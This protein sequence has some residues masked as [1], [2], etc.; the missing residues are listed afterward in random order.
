M[1]GS[2][3]GGS[4]R[5]QQLVE[6]SFITRCDILEYDKEAVQLF[7]LTLVTCKCSY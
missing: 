2:L 1:A 7:V 3:D 5:P 6:A 4:F